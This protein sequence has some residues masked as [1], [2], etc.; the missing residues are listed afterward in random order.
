MPTLGT[1]EFVLLGTAAFVAVNVLVG[2]MR[3]YQDQLIDDV[4]SQWERE[5][6]R[7]RE[8]GQAKERKR[9]KLARQRQREEREPQE[10]RRRERAA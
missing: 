9:Q 7:R 5:L 8:E 3:R 10:R 2:L 4:R 1:V 6:Q